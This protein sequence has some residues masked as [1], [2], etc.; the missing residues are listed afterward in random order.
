MMVIALNAFYPN[1]EHLKPS[2]KAHV[3]RTTLQSNVTNRC[4]LVVTK[5][6]AGSPKT[7]YLVR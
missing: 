2:F 1:A 3:D 7:C 5:K 6:L 4:V